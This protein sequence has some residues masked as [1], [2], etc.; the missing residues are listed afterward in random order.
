MLWNTFASFLSFTHF[1]SDTSTSH[2]AIL[3][4]SNYCLKSLEMVTAVFTLIFVTLLGVSLLPASKSTT[5][6]CK[7]DSECVG[8]CE[9]VTDPSGHEYTQCRVRGNVYPSHTCKLDADC[10][11]KCAKHFPDFFHKTCG[12]PWIFN[13]LCEVIYPSLINNLWI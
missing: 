9:K 2:I 12:W 7:D 1:R 13:K 10:N 11:M 5:L 3:R 8:H 4:L 6:Y